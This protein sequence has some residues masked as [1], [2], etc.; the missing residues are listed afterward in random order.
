M[1]QALATL[2]APVPLKPARGPGQRRARPPN[3]FGALW[4]E[5]FFLL[6]SL[7]TGDTVQYRGQWPHLH[8]S[9]W[10]TTM[11]LYNLGLQC[12]HHKWTVQNRLECRYHEFLKAT[13]WPEYTS[14]CTLEA[15]YKSQG[16]A[17]WWVSDT[18]NLNFWGVLTP[19]LAVP[20]RHI[21][22]SN[23]GVKM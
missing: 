10:H 7:L 16:R 3:G 21:A 18:P 14:I 11:D 6:R 8:T 22:R 13:K 9:L 4:G 12:K 17:K 15:N 5:D 23:D 2:N 20:V 19:T 1:A